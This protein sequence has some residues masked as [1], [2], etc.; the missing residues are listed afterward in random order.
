MLFKIFSG[1]SLQSSPD[2]S[3][4]PPPHTKVSKDDDDETQKNYLEIA[5]NVPNPATWWQIR[6][7][8]CTDFIISGPCANCGQAGHWELI[9]PFSLDKA[10]QSPKL[11]LHRTVCWISWAWVAK[12]N[13][14][15][16][17]LHHLPSV[18]VCRRSLPF[19]VWWG[20]QQGQWWCLSAK[21]APKVSAASSSLQ[22]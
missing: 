7:L 19:S 4:D 3:S 14:A 11:L 21:A 16:G 20:G 17:P 13:D 6:S 22:V 9:A 12:T 2:P 8:H 1:K 10:G 18:S 5:L 15:L